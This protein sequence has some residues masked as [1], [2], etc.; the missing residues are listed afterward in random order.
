MFNIIDDFCKGILHCT[1]VKLFHLHVTNRLEFTIIRNLAQEV[2]REAVDNCS[3]LMINILVDIA[4][5]ISSFGN[6]RVIFQENIC[7]GNPFVN[8]IIFYKR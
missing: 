3:S 6:L 7:I 4:G 2:T 8:A 5:Q 1:I